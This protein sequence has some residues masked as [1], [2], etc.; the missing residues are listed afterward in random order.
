[1]EGGL[2]LNCDYIGMLF[3]DLRF[4]DDLLGVRDVATI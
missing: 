3:A 1:M 4:H 2:E